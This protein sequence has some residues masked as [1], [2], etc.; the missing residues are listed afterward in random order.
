MIF[1]IDLGGLNDGVS[2][3][4]LIEIG[5]VCPKIGE[6]FPRDFVPMS[7]CACE[8]LALDD[9][10]NYDYPLVLQANI[11]Y[12]IIYVKEIQESFLKKEL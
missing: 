1:L 11:Y 12:A 2:K 3:G 8:A 6:E 4:L 10:G 9:Y 7:P 5:E